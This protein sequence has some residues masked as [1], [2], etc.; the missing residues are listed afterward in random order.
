MLLLGAPAAAGCG[1]RPL[2]FRA[3]RSLPRKVVQINPEPL[4]TA[5]GNRAC[6]WDAMK[7]T[8]LYERVGSIL[9]DL[10]APLYGDSIE[11]HKIKMLLLVPFLSGH[12]RH[13]TA[14]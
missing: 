14:S 7:T 1:K 5:S 13:F 8:T 3:K 11:R 10:D 6:V 12:E 4:A 9:E 2:P